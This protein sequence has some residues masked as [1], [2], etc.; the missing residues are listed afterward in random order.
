MGRMG[1]SVLALLA[2]A[3][4]HPLNADENAR[5]SLVVKVQ[6]RAGRPLPGATLEVAPP[7]GILAP[8]A[9]RTDPDGAGRFLLPPGAGYTVRV[10]MPGFGTQSSEALKIAAG[11][12][13]TV[14]FA[15][16][17]QVVEEVKVQATIE[18]L[19][20][21]R[22]SFNDEALEDLPI[23]GRSYQNALSLAPGV[24]DVNHDGNPN[25]HG[26]R[27]RDFKATVDGISNVDPL[28]GTY[29][30][31]VN[32]D[33][34]DELEIVTTGASAEY[35]GAVG[36]FARII[37]KQGTNTLSGSAG[38][39]LRSSYLDALATKDELVDYHD[40][41]PTLNLTGPIVKDRLYFALFHEYIDKGQP[42]RIPADES[43]TAVTRG[44]PTQL[45]PGSEFVIATQGS[46]NLDKLTWQIGSRNKLSLQFLSDPFTTGPLGVST[47]AGVDSGYDYKQGGPSY[48]A[49]WTLQATSNFYV[50]T[51]VG[52]N[53]TSVSYVPVTNGNK[54]FCATDEYGPTR[55][56]VYGN[57][58]GA[59]LDED[60]CLNLSTGIRSGS[61][62][63]D[64]SDRRKR[65]TWKTDLSYYADS[66]L[67][68]SHTVRAGVI[69]ESRSY[70]GHQR[71]RAVSDWQEFPPSPFNNG[72]IGDGVIHR[73][74]S[75][76]GDPYEQVN[77]ADGTNYGLYLEDLFSP[78][79][80]LSIRIGARAD[81]ENL[82]ADGYEPFDPAREEKQYRKQYTRCVR[83]STLPGGPDRCA[84]S[85]WFWFHSY[86][87]FPAGGASAVRSIIETGGVLARKPER[88]RISNTN[89]SPRLSVN[90]SPGARG[91]TKV[92]ATAGRYYGETFLAVPSFEQ[93]PDS[94]NYT[95]PVEGQQYDC[96]PVEG[97][98]GVFDC[99]WK[100]VIA[101]DRQATVALASIRQV[102]RKLR[103]PHQDEY[104]AGISQEILPET[105]MTVTYIRRD[106]RDQLQ[107]VDV[108]HYV[109]VPATP[110]RPARLSVHNPL[111]NQIQLVGNYNSSKYRAWE[112]AVH[113]RF[114]RNWELEASYVYS[115]AEGNAEDFNQTLGN[116]PGLTD[117]EFGP[118]D[119]DVRHALKV[120]ARLQIPRW[121]MRFSGTAS[122]R[123]GLPYSVVN[124]IFLNDLP[125]Q[126]GTV[127]IGYGNLRT[128]YPSG[129]RNDQ[130]NEGVYNLDLG[131]RKD[132]AVGRWDLT[133][134]LD[135]FNV[136]DDQTVVTQ[137]TIGS[138]PS[139]AYPA[140]RQ[141]QLG[142]KIVY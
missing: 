128:F 28:T 22:T 115:H 78:A 99:K 5:A 98:P 12:A 3:A 84:R 110:F 7:A 74:V 43:L 126:F 129:A 140:Q 64:Y 61:Y 10:S 39:Y 1:L 138:T 59:P 81:Q 34:I 26:A 119:Y 14:L 113:R 82:E 32:P 71:V 132:V 73:A 133:L 95:Y 142:A 103:T 139:S 36:G 31:E 45:A 116:D 72:R 53:R 52:M 131:T 24:N 51:T 87:I 90:W 18:D 86:E 49:L 67:G 23:V 112:L 21:G 80:G 96:V 92:F 69:A 93:G 40:V 141:F 65:L 120:N 137:Q 2:A 68:I 85:G 37:T 62:N 124:Q 111:F 108:N 42:V 107:D 83:D 70:E 50:Q 88:Y 46:R 30:S 77:T 109:V 123:S 102:D 54:N 136:L 101:G 57:T 134:S 63:L 125:K 11:G 56:D 100:S 9:V 15:L 89:L 60:Y 121:N 47:V 106:Y 17:R 94:F 6:D 127:T 33:A 20:E 41:R 135:I 44:R 76:P 38:L 8:P 35:G 16:R 29:Q 97:V 122:Y 13:K 117:E 118:L 105:S 79:R 19:G 4:L 27:E 75:V 66:L 130:R 48:Q 55:L 58:G 91:L 104:T 114:L 25:V